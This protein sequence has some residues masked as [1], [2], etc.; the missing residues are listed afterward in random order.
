MI[1]DINPMRKEFL[2]WGILLSAEDDIAVLAESL[3]YLSMQPML[4][5]LSKKGNYPYKMTDIQA[6]L[7]LTQLAKRERIQGI[8]LEIA[9][10]FNEEFC[11][12]PNWKSHRKRNTRDMLGLCIS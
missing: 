4:F 9:E 8:R 6:A 10:G 2:T 1:R 7:G 11:K 3:K 12:M 5:I